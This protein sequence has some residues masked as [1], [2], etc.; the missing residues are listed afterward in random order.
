VS[1]F[2]SSW[3]SI[4]KIL[5]RATGVEPATSSLGIFYWNYYFSFADGKLSGI[6]NCQNLLFRLSDF[7]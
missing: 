4:R 5:E 2:D 1:I 7:N 3:I 6:F